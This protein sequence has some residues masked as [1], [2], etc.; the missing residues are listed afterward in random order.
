VEPVA[1]VDGLENQVSHRPALRLCDFGPSRPN[2]GRLDYVFAF[3]HLVKILA[4][5][6][7]SSLNIGKFPTFG[8]HRQNVA[9]TFFPSI[10][11]PSLTGCDFRIDSK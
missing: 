9:T 2:F 1:M 6:S 8:A 11:S 10:M 5:V 4:S 7:P 3:G